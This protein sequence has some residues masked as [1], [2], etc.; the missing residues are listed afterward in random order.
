MTRSSAAPSHG[1]I[2]A[3][4]YTRLTLGGRGRKVGQLEHAQNIGS[5]WADE[6]SSLVVQG[7]RRMADRPI[8]NRRRQDSSDRGN[9]SRMIGLGRKDHRAPTGAMRYEA[10]DRG[11]IAPRGGSSQREAVG[12][13][14]DTLSAHG[15]VELTVQPTSSGTPS[16]AT[17]AAPSS[18]CN[19][20]TTTRGMGVILLF[21]YSRPT[22][23][24]TSHRPKLQHALSPSTVSHF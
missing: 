21:F 14:S 24:S 16:V 9:A 23:R 10:S 4:S 1:G 13:Q 11:V 22:T 20:P 2:E 7:C 12:F 8:R 17:G 6:G 19:L 18:T 3:R 15:T 5:Y